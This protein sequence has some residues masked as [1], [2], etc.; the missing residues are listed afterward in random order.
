MTYEYFSISLGSSLMF[1][2]LHLWHRFSVDLGTH[3]LH[4]CHTYF[5]AYLSI[6]W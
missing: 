1:Y 6:I 3:I 4:K 5:I 2:P